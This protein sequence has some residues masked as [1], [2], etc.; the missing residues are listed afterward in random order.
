MTVHRR[1]KTEV[2]LHGFLAAVLMLGA[3]SLSACQTPRQPLFKPGQTVSRQ[4]AQRPPYTRVPNQ[5]RP[6]SGLPPLVGTP[7][8]M[9]QNQ[10]QAVL[11]RAEYRPVVQSDGVTRVGLLLPLT[12][13]NSAL[14]KDML[15]AA[16]LALFDFAGDSFELIVQ[17]TMGQ[18]DLA[19][20]ATDK[21]INNGAS[22]IL[23]PLLS[24]SVEAVTPL[25]RSAG[26]NSIAFS[27]NRAVASEN[28]FLMGFMP[29]EEVERVIAY[30]ASRGV[31]D[32]A[33]LA[34]DNAYGNMVVESARHAVAARGGY[35]A[36]VALYDPYTED[37]TQIIRDLGNY[38]ERRAAL[39]AQRKELEAMD[40]QLSRQALKRLENLQTLGDLPYTALLI[41]EGGKRLQTIAAHLPF[42]D[43]DPKK[44]R[45]LGTG[46]WDVAGIGSEPALVGGWYAAPD[47][48]ARENFIERFRQTY[49]RRPARLATLAYDAVALAAVLGRADGGPLFDAATLTA[50]SG[51]VGRDGI[52][53]F[54]PDGSNQRG[55]AVMEVQERSTRV[56]APPADSFEDVIN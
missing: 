20:E 37:F 56:I 22:L 40:D 47:P 30:S 19:V 16:Q 52:F 12:G 39:L 6:Q 8:D 44:V 10:T 17:D 23:G 54:L 4:P 55:L 25:V 43:I 9:A 34:P 11:P 28:V 15:N 48:T 21:A 7:Q 27:N 29:G 38:D 31:T 35:L 49:G 26:I 41:A 1:K 13:A 24:T 14:A 32:F 50:E 51:Y 3:F 18:P 53:R 46:Q 33:V 36:R 45:M 5:Q 2:L 42:Y